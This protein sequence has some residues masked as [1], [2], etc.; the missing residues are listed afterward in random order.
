MTRHVD[1]LT[2]LAD[3]GCRARGYSDP[4]IADALGITRQA[5]CQRFGR[6]KSA[7]PA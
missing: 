6:K 3:E 4:V 7:R 1:A 2:E 5:V